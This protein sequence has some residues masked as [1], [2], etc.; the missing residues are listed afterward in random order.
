MSTEMDIADRVDAGSPTDTADPAWV[1]AEPAAARPGPR[2]VV[3]RKRLAAEPGAVRQARRFV[4]AVLMD[5]KLW[6]LAERAV[7]CT[8]EL[9]ANA[10]QAC[11]ADGAPDGAESFE[12]V[13]ALFGAS[14]IVEVRDAS[15]VLPQRPLGPAPGVDAAEAL[16]AENGRGLLLVEA[17]SDRLMWCRTA[18]GKSVWFEL[19]VGA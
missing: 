3:C 11:T 1:W 8:S 9:A 5:W 7:Q 14:V 15:P 6:H 10:V 4:S 19:A 18:T 17:L 13:V 12:L 2:P 16:L